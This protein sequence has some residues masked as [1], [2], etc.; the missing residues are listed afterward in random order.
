M[1]VGA[2]D[3][4][5]V[6]AHLDFTCNRKLPFFDHGGFT[7]VVSLGLSFEEE[8]SLLELVD[9]VFIKSVSGV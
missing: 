3:L 1:V 2:V 4:V 9:T 8:D 5:D 6:G 7:L